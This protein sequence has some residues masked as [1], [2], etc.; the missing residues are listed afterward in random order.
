[1]YGEDSGKRPVKRFAV[2]AGGQVSFIQV[3]DIDWI[4]GNGDYA[5]LHVGKKTYLVRQPLHSLEQRLSPADFVR[6]HRSAIVR[7]DC[8]RGVTAL[9]NRDCELTLKDGAQL[10]SSRTYSKALW[11]ALRD[12][13]L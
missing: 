5:S 3:C 13:G 7:L 12:L 6:V 9:S 1:M 4:E 2:R 8:I 10:R 11:S